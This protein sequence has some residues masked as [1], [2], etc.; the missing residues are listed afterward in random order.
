MTLMPG[1]RAATLGRETVE[2]LRAGGYTAPSGRLVDL[3][4]S[5][6]ASA[7][8]TV[9]YPPERGIGPPATGIEPS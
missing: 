9:E 6:E 1:E 3:R 4:A 7:R 2:L 5:L 8:G